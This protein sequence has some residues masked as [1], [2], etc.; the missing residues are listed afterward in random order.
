MDEVPGII[1]VEEKDQIRVRIIIIVQARSPY[2]HFPALDGN[3]RNRGELYLVHRWSGVDLRLDYEHETLK[4]L[5]R[6][7][8]RPVHIESRAEDK[9]IL[10][11]FDGET[12]EVAELTPTE[13]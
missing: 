3:F 9:G 12:H 4:N 7:W 1:I 13:E 6:I 10:L 5:F 8:S 2:P 11:S